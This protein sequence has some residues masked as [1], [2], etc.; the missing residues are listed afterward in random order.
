VVENSSSAIDYGVN[1][2]YFLHEIDAWFIDKKNPDQGLAAHHYGT[3]PNTKV[4]VFWN[5][6]TDDPLRAFDL[7]FKE[8][9]VKSLMDEFGQQPT[10]D[11]ASSYHESQGH[12]MPLFGTL[13][14]EYIA[15]VGRTLQLDLREEDF[16]SIIS[17]LSFHLSKY[18]FKHHS[19]LNDAHKSLVS[20]LFKTT[21]LKGYNFKFASFEQLVRTIHQKSEAVYGNRFFQQSHLPSLPPLIMVFDTMALRNIAERSWDGESKPNYQHIYDTIMRQVSSFVGIEVDDSHNHI[22]YNFILEI[23]YSGLGLGYDI[24][25]GRA[26]NPLN[27]EP[28]EDPNMVYESLIDRAMIQVRLDLKEN[29]PEL[30]FASCTRLPDVITMQSSGQP[31]FEETEKTVRRYAVDWTSP[32]GTLKKVEGWESITT[33]GSRNSKGTALS[34]SQ[35]YAPRSESPKPPP[36][37]SGQIYSEAALPAKLRAIHGG[38]YPQSDIVIADD[39]AGEIAARTWIDD[40]VGLDRRRLL[41]PDISYER[42]L[43][44]GPEKKLASSVLGELASAIRDI[45]SDFLPN[46]WTRIETG[47]GTVVRK[48]VKWSEERRQKKDERK[49]QHSAINPKRAEQRLAKSSDRHERLKIW[50]KTVDASKSPYRVIFPPISIR[51]HEIRLVIPTTEEDS[52]ANFTVD[53]RPYLLDHYPMIKRSLF[54]VT[55]YEAAAQGDRLLLAR[56]V[57]EADINA[58]AGPHGTPL[59]AACHEGDER[60]PEVKFLIDSGALVSASTPFITSKL[61]GRELPTYV[62]TKLDEPSQMSAYPLVI[63]SAGGHI[64]IVRVLVQAWKKGEVDDNEKKKVH[65]FA[66]LEAC[67]NGKEA[68]VELLLN[69]GADVNYGEEITSNFQNYH[70]PLQL[71]CSSTGP[72]SLVKFLIEK[73]ADVSHESPL[74]GSL[75]NPLVAAFVGGR[76]EIIALLLDKGLKWPK[77]TDPAIKPRTP[78]HHSTIQRL[79]KMGGVKDENLFSHNKLPESKQQKE[80]KQRIIPFTHRRKSTNIAQSMGSQQE[81]DQ[82]DQCKCCICMLDEKI[83]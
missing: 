57:E 60:E 78:L 48:S 43:Q 77:E 22:P 10:H 83:L 71:A 41:D 29:H 45:N 51:N 15:P 63:A 54:T 16:A 20:Q 76:D 50:I 28:L 32:Y 12:V 33:V 82:F 4:D 35:R 40:Y 8:R 65:T 75:L 3:G 27:G 19:D 38:L 68:P 21:M 47:T 62:T 37:S 73:N 23:T 1:K 5:D 26:K 66:L 58:P 6:M 34:T 49:L 80:S 24:K 36:V 46:R 61:Y 64:K 11:W 55:A 67:R 56:V 81:T 74:R 52:I 18:Q 14:E 42:W 7:D 30:V 72:D 70:S 31:G 53:G 39:P 13:W 17:Y 25:T 69:A 79:K 2:Q 9:R 59:T 44:E